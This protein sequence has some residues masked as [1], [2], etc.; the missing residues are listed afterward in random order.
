[1]P[2]RITIIGLGQLGASIGLALGKHK[3]KII[4]TGLDRLSA[5]A[6]QCEKQ[7]CI[8]K[9]AYN[10]GQAVDKCDLVILALPVSEI[11]EA[12]NGIA[13][14]LRENAVVLDTCAAMINSQKL[15]GEILPADR[16]FIGFYPTINPAFVL[17][18]FKHEAD[19]GLFTDAQVVITCNEN[20]PAEALTLASDLAKLLGASPYYC[21]PYEF[22]GWQ[23][24][25]SVLPRLAAAALISSVSN[26]PGWPDALKISDAS[27]GALAAALDH[28]DAG[29]WLSNRENISRT[30]HLYI[31][32]LKKFDR[33]LLSCDAAQLQTLLDAA[34]ND[35][36]EWQ[37]QRRTPVEARREQQKIK[38]SGESVSHALGISQLNDM[39][40]PKK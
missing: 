19:A 4:R 35:L 8:D 23:A 17:D 18:E 12:L 15:A 2:T 6:L 9:V 39:I 11:N 10:L 31:D 30:L 37:K 26:Q 32:T 34:Q 14:S 28:P 38:V 22:E 27:F 29:A 3:D 13:P 24:R 7:G 5:R 36:S 40:K 1:M 21:D 25:A 33:A 16:H 20:T